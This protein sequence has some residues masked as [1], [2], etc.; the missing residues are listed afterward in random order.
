MSFATFIRTAPLAVAALLVSQFVTLAQANET[1]SPSDTIE[2]E[3]TT[4][5]FE[6]AFETTFEDSSDI[7]A[8]D[9]F[10]ADHQGRRPRHPVPRPRP[11]P[12]RHAPRPYPRP[13]PRWPSPPYY[14][15]YPQYSYT[16]YAENL[17][18]EWFSETS[19]DPQWAQREALEDCYAWGSTECR[20]L[21]CN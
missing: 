1:L 6:G 18:G 10:E 19:I 4:E 21:G 12:P 20:A 14:P 15:P 9:A 11:R 8:E 7:Q 2:L 5:E 16:C 17:R 3:S 13:I